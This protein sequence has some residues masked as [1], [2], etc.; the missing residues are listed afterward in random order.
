MSYCTAQPMS[1]VWGDPVLTWRQANMVRCHWEHTKSV[2]LQGSAPPMM[3]WFLRSFL[4]CDRIKGEQP[5][6]RWFGHLLGITWDFTQDEHYHHWLHETYPSVRNKYQVSCWSNSAFKRKYPCSKK[7]SGS[8]L[9]RHVHI[10]MLHLLTQS[11]YGII[12]GK[13]SRAIC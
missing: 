10:D 6:Q 12:C 7:A 11:G 2:W 3:L 9:S 8:V 4:S 13:K 1:V 5:Y